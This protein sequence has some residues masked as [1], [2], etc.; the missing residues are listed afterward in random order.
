MLADEVKY[1]L[2]VLLVLHGKR[3][4]ACSKRGG[5][6]KEDCPLAEHK[7][8]GAGKATTTTT[9]AT[10]SAKAEVKAEMKAVVLKEEPA[11]ALPSAPPSR[12]SPE[13]KAGAQ[14][15]TKVKKREDGEG[16]VGPVPTRAKRVR[17]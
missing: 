4:A 7:R 2:H 5:S 3:C 9:T 8:R 14:G 1:D 16:A 17:R 10:A 13:S 11:G 6:A 12:A 15:G